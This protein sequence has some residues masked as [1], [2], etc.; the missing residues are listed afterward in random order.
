MID[1]PPTKTE[2][3]ANAL[4]AAQSGGT[5]SDDEI[6]RITVKEKWQGAVTDS[7][8]FVAVPLTLLRLQHDYKLSPTDMV[9]LI[10]LLAHWWDPARAVYPRTTTI[11][12]RMGVD[13][14]TIQRSTNKLVNSGLMKREFQED[15]RR[16]FAFDGLAKRLARDVPKALAIQGRETFD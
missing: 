13:K 4:E 2:V 6:V 11:A 9:V 3:T 5:G 15:G 16:T 12:K 7:A 8:G 10:N 1:E 14:R